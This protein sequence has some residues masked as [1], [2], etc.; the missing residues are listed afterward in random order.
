MSKLPMKVSCLRLLGIPL[1]LA[2]LAGCI[3]SPLWRWDHYEVRAVVRGSR[4]DITI[5]GQPVPVEELKD[6]VAV[7]ADDA[8][9]PGLPPDH[10]LRII[11]CN[12]LVVSIV[13]PVGVPRAPSAYRV[14]PGVPSAAGAAA[15][16]LSSNVV[17]PG[18]WPLALTGVYLEAYDGFVQIDSIHAAQAWAQVLVHARRQHKGE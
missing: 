14:F 17:D 5:D 8:L 4:C 11:A 2:T 12:G 6:S 3:N 9:N 13:A 16:G 1:L 7:M 15:V 10:R 18:M